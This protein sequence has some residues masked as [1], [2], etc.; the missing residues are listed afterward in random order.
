MMLI[1]SGSVARVEKTL[2]STLDTV[3]YQK[4]IVRVAKV[5]GT[6][7]TWGVKVYDVD[8]PGWR[9]IW[10]GQTAEGEFEL[11]LPEAGVSKIALLE[12]YVGGPTTQVW[13]DYVAIC[14]NSLLVP[15]LG[16]LVKEMRITRPLLNKAVAGAKFHIPNTG[17]AYNG[18]IKGHDVV[19]IWLARSDADLGTIAAKAFGGRVVTPTN[20]GVQYG[21]F[22]IDL[23]CHGHA[24]ELNIPPTLVQKYYLATNG[25]TIIEDDLGLCSYIAKNPDATKWFDNA[26][27]SGSTDDRINSTH[28]CVYDEELPMTV[29]QEILDKAKNPAA[30]EGFD[31]YEMPSGCLVGHLRNSLDFVSPITSNG[32]HVSSQGSGGRSGYG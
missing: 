11:T 29:I 27:S 28:D 30:V 8:L 19:I 10:T 5:A 14:K 6:N 20:Q 24:Y 3:T 12:E 31:M 18:L 16:D 26:G 23:D 15:D 25:L 4:I 13:F 7:T 21:E 17:G 1:G 22:Y 32:L 9:T 2:P